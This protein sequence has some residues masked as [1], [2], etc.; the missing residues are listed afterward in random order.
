MELH[1]G[2][3]SGKAVKVSEDHRLHTIS[4]I[5]YPIEAFSHN[6]DVYSVAS[7][8]VSL[9]NIATYTGLLY[10]AKSTTD[11][12]IHFESIRTS[13]SQTTQWQMIK[14]PTTGT[15]ISGGTVIN[16]VTLNFSSGKT[17]I[18]T[19]KVTTAGAGL[20]ITDGTLVGQWRTG[21]DGL[22]VALLQGS[23]ILGAGNSM[24]LTCLP[25]TNPTTVASTIT[26]WEEPLASR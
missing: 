13:S 25:F 7:D 18:G 23:L 5:E 8:F 22:H 20:T 15:L 26:F 9:T 19:V 24:A 3:G 6:G 11:R 10:I 1:D 14:N 21:V 17:S 2:T 16:P 4:L 12:V